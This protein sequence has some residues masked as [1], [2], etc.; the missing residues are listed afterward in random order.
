M[1]NTFKLIGLSLLVMLLAGCGAEDVPSQALT[2][3]AQSA[4]EAVGSVLIQKGAVTNA[5]V[6]VKS[7][8]GRDIGKATTNAEGHYKVDSNESGLFIA[9]A[10]DSSGKAYYSV[11]QSANMNITHLGDYL[12]RRWFQ[13]RGQDVE[14]TFASSASAQS[15]PNVQ[16]LNVLANQIVAIPAYAMQKQPT[17]LF[18]GEMTATLAKI[19]KGATIESDTQLRIN[20]PE[21]NFNGIYTLKVPQL[22]KGNVVFEGVE[23][24][25]S[26]NA[27]LVKG[28]IAAS[29]S[30]VSV[31]GGKGALLGSA[32]G[33][34]VAA[35]ANGGSNEHWM[36]D[37]WDYIKDKKLGQ[38]VI[39]GTHDSGTY[40]LAWGTGGD[41]AKTQINSIGDQLKDGIRYF[42]LRVREA[43]HRNCADPSVWWLFHTWDSYRLQV[44]LDEIVSFLTK[45]G[46]E[47][48]VIILD[49]QETDIELYNDERA[50]NTLLGMIQDKLKPYLVKPYVSQAK[51]FE[52]YLTPQKPWTERSV[53]DLVSNNQRVVVLLENGLYDRIKAQPTEWIADCYGKHIDYKNFSNRTTEMISAYDE[54]Y[55][56]SSG[57]IQYL[58]SSEFDKDYLSSAMWREQVA[59]YEERWKIYLKKVRSGDMKKW[60]YNLGFP[61]SALLAKDPDEPNRFKSKMSDRVNDYKNLQKENRL[62]VLQL[63]SRPSNSWYAEATAAAFAGDDLLSYAV[64]EINRPLSFK[65]PCA[66]GWLGKRLRLGIEGDPAKWNSPNIIIADNYKASDWVLP[67]NES[68]KWVKGF[69]GSYVDMIIELNKIGRGKNRLANVTDMQDGQCLQ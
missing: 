16:E 64:R 33:P 50:R 68:G 24:T 13:A 59:N 32:S 27:P 66:E 63:V 30:G 49:F 46:N 44:A 20:L 43:H 35:S 42:D 29:V 25:S 45:P 48:E 58:I 40:Q 41:T 7:Y 1:L 54:D 2:P 47:N 65:G 23:E 39:P 51:S 21:I 52:D 62:R 11:G 3:G 55:A 53:S 12:L 36:K 5:T 67:N 19:L 18:G 10:R 6:I 56:K 15:L 28:P 8:E 61:D 26:D 22:K 34:M 9:E 31:G 38:L 60:E 37:N 4:T 14:S 57:Q 17:E 69:S